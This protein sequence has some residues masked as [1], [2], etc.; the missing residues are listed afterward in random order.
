MIC[1]LQKNGTAGKQYRV[2]R[3][4]KNVTDVGKVVE[5]EEKTK[6]DVWNGDH[7]NKLA[8]TDGTIFSPFIAEGQQMTSFSAELCR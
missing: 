3:G 6:L 8:G 5:F 4:I 2:K 1:F 7:C